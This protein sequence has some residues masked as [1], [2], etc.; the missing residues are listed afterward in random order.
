MVSMMD[1]SHTDDTPTWSFP[2]SPME[3][4]HTPGAVQAHLLTLQTQLHALQQQHHQLNRSIH[5][6]GGWTKPPQ[7]P[8]NRPRPMRL[9]PNPRVAPPPANAGHA[10]AIRGLARS[11]WSRRTSNTC[12]RH[13]VPVARG[14]LAAPRSPTPSRCSRCHLWRWTSPTSSCTTPNVEGVARDAKPTS[15]GYSPR[16]TARV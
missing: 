15:P 12:I 5:C 3:W 6:K 10:R 14:R 13:R 7:P 16:A 1:S 2:F 8:V 9:S 4:D 11:C